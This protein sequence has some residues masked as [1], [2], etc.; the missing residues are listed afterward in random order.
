MIVR[1]IQKWKK[2]R[3]KWNYNIAENCEKVL[4]KHQRFH[5][6]TREQQNTEG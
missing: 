5:K 6:K 1:M 3:K 2:S 4:L